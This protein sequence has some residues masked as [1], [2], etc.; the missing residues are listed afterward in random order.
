MSSAD[1][2]EPSGWKPAV[3][4]HIDWMGIRCLHLS[5]S[6]ELTNNFIRGFL[7]TRDGAVWIATD[8]G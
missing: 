2:M 8:E 1:A 6:G 4:A 3:A 7:Q 5:A